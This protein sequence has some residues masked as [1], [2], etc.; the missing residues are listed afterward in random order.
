MRL[1]EVAPA[2]LEEVV[3]ISLIARNHSELEPPTSAADWAVRAWLES[4]DRAFVVRAGGNAPPVW[5]HEAFKWGPHPWP[6]RFA[7]LPAMPFTDCGLMAALSTAVY[8]WRGFTALP[9]QVILLFNR[10]SAQGWANLWTRVGLP[11]HWC[12]DHFAYHE[13]TGVVDEIG[14][15]RLWDAL[16]RFWLPVTGR[17]VYENI[18]ALRACSEGPIRHLVRLGD[19]AIISGRWYALPNL[20]SRNVPDG[21]ADSVP[22]KSRQS[23]NVA[24]EV[25]FNY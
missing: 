9:V 20:G 1:E 13:L 24:G 14:R 7:D 12:S 25:C 2:H 15:M 22:T 16:G 10:E 8:R 18:V 11:A 19:T 6:V 3:G 5:I 17:A 23:C 21:R 4:L